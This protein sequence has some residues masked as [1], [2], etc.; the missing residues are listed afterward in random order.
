M[1]AATEAGLCRSEDD[2]PLGEE[3][4]PAVRA[5]HPTKKLHHLTKKLHRL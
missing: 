4:L 3:H 1:K 5:V 2:A